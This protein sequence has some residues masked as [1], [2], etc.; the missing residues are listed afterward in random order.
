[1]KTNACLYALVLLLP[2]SLTFAQNKTL[3]LE[4]DQ[5]TLSI[6]LADGSVLQIRAD[7]SAAATAE[8]GFVCDQGA[9]CEDVQVSMADPDGSLTLSRS[10]VRQGGILQ[11]DWNSRGAWECTGSGLTGTSWNQDNPKP[12]SG[13]QSVSTEGVAVGEYELELLCANGPVSA[14]RTATL[15]V[16]EE[17]SAVP[18]ECSGV[19]QLSDYEGWQVAT[20]AQPPFGSNES[21]LFS[22]FFGAW[23]GTG[24]SDNIG[25]L[26]GEY[27]S[28]PFTTGIL[29]SDSRGQFN[30]E[31]P[32]VSTGSTIGPGPL[33]VSISRCP[34]DFD[35][36]AGAVPSA[37]C[38]I[39]APFS[40]SSIRWGGPE[41]GRGC[42]L[43]S[44]TDYYF[45]LVYTSSSVGELPPVQAECGG[46][47][48]CGNLWWAVGSE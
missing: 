29:D 3:E 9:S 11:I 20:D 23:P 15:T 36:Q 38:V 40:F 10:V 34:G 33:I 37:A 41:S 12:A 26:K 4:T 7:G 22:T 32:S 46:K 28:L 24:N 6:P 42:E 14:T 48:R 13:Q 30:R 8:S 18:A 44:N 43:S 47:A 25:I 16:E 35:P 31:Q 39:S 5:E 21:Q 1:M 19:A 2:A 17:S 27:L 45:N